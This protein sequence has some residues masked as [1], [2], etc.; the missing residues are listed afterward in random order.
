MCAPI[1]NYL[2]AACISPLLSSHRSVR[3][4]GMTVSM[5][6]IVTYGFYSHWFLSVW[7]FLAATMSTTVLCHFPKGQS[8]WAVLNSGTPEP[9]GIH[10]RSQAYMPNRVKWSGLQRT[11]GSN[12]KSLKG[13][14]S[15]ELGLNRP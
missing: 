3:V 4:F 15:E 14:A 7:G 5:A 13:S 2:L 1:R 12:G 10:F 9:S 8:G 6:L 11:D